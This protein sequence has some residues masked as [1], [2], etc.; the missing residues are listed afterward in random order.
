MPPPDP[1]QPVRAATRAAAAAALVDRIAGKLGRLADRWQPE[2]AAGRGDADDRGVLRAGLRIAGGDPALARAA[3]AYGEVRPWIDADAAGADDRFLGLLRRHRDGDAD[4]AGLAPR[5]FVP[6]AVFRGEKLHLRGATL[7]LPDPEAAWIL[8]HELFVRRAY[9]F[10][11]AGP[12]PPVIVDAGAHHGLS[13]AWAKLRWPDARIT[14]FEPLAANREVIADNARRNGWKRLTVHPFAVDGE[15]GERAFHAAEGAS[16]AGSLTDR[17][18]RAGGPTRELKVRVERLSDFLPGRVD[19]LKIDVEGVELGVLRDLAEAG[20]LA[21]VRRLFL[22]YH[23]GP[24]LPRKGLVDALG[25]LHKHDFRVRVAS[26]LD[27]GD[28]DG[29]GADAPFESMGRYTLDVH[30]TAR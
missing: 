2:L 26:S 11:H 12:E 29:D 24:G 13:I 20:T 15:P 21:R 10:E 6:A 23:H 9:D 16:M 17:V 18:A 14:A 3:L 7:R 30:A 4:P 1:F 25:L 28:G 5:R 22:E 8:L 27:G 19:F